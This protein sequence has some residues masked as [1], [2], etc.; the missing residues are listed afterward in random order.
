[1]I[2]L[3]FPTV[4]HGLKKVS[5][6]PEQ[7]AW[8]KGWMNIRNSVLIFPIAIASE[9]ANNITIT[10][11]SPKTNR[12]LLLF[13]QPPNIDIRLDPGKKAK[14]S[15]RHEKYVHFFGIADKGFCSQQTIE[16]PS[17]QKVQQ[18][19]GHFSDTKFFVIHNSSVSLVGLI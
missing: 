18:C 8:C 5:S 11:S 10:D 2:F 13:L 19:S 16:K 14:A 7:E 1:L 12:N 4:N 15:K 17:T 3:P 6:V 9:S